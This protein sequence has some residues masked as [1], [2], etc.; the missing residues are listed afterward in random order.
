MALARTLVNVPDVLLFDE[1]FAAL[2]FQTKLLIESDA[3]RLVRDQQRAMLL[4]T[5]DIEEAVSLSDRVIVLAPGGRIFDDIRIDLPH[6]RR[7]ADPKV[8]TLQAEL[9]GRFEEMQFAGP[10]TSVGA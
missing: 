4:I 1:P 7:A 10:S 6:P 9:L 8:A 2:D 3:A 5:H